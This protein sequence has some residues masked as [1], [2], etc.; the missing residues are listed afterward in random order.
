MASAQ[1]RTTPSS[2]KESIIIICRVAKPEKQI[3][4]SIYADRG[5]N[6]KITV[7]CS[8][9]TIPKSTSYIF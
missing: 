6:L 5:Q 4:V 1:G 8:N 3:F 2:A 7:D 9:P